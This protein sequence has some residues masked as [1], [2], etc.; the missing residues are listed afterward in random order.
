MDWFG[1][2]LPKDRV[3]KRP[4]SALKS[5]LRDL[6]TRVPHY[7]DD[8]DQGKLIYPACRARRSDAGGDVGSIWDHARLE[9]I[10]M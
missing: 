10:A 8:V 9:A 5:L 3:H 4:P 1:W 2:Q 6:E 7:L